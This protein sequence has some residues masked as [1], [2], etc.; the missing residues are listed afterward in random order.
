M[1]IG[2]VEVAMG[3]VGVVCLVTLSFGRD[4]VKLDH[5]KALEAARKFQ[6]RMPYR[7]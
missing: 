7:Q 4:K 5:A 1:R 2:A 6:L 3:L